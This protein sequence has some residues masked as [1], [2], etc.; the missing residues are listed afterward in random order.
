MKFRLNQGIIGIIGG[1]VAG[2]AHMSDIVQL[3]RCKSSSMLKGGI[4][5][6]LPLSNKSV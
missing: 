4:V 2:V 1:T 6:K 5:W 3:R